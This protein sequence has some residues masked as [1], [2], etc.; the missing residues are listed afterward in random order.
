MMNNQTNSPTLDH[1]DDEQI[2]AAL[3]ESILLS[4][5]DEILGQS[6]EAYTD[7]GVHGCRV[8]VARNDNATGIAFLVGDRTVRITVG[9]MKRVRGELLAQRPR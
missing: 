2:V 8:N 9:I 5:P 6:V 7:G 4:V 1:A 3:I